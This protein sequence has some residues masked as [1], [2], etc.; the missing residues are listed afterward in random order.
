MK[1]IIAIKGM[2]CEHCRSHVEKALNAIPGVE[3][4]VDL[5]KNEAVVSFD[6]DISD[7]IFIDAVREAGYEAVSVAEKK[8]LFGR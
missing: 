8:G 7:Q 1:K 2:S 5:K 3:A 4:R 6:G